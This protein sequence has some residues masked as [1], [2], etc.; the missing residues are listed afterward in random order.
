M[1]YILSI[2]HIYQTS[3]STKC[4]I[5]P[6]IYFEL[7]VSTRCCFAGV[8]YG[9]VGEA[10]KCCLSLTA[11]DTILGMMQGYKDEVTHLRAEMAQ[12]KNGS[13]HGMAT[14]SQLLCRL[15]LYCD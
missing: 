9:P 4:D 1:H 14:Y 15:K 5:I 8:V 7:R 13:Q 12:L 6:P 3:I 11:M 10:Q 2:V